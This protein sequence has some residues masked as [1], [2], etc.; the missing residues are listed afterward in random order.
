MNMPG[1]S[2]LPVALMGGGGG[3][4]SAN[5]NLLLWSEE[6][7]RST[8]VKGVGVAVLANQGQDE[9]GGTTADLVTLT[10]GGTLTQISTIA[11]S[12]GG[13]YIGSTLGSSSRARS[14]VS[15]EFDGVPYV[16]SV[17][18]E[19]PLDFQAEVGLVLFQSGG[20]IAARLRDTGDA[21][22]ILI[23]QAKLETPTLTAYVKREGT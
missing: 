1:I 4:P 16:F 20:F 21:P 15:G 9:Q 2:G 17:F 7:D 10:S 11:V 19:D 8:W 22:S 13:P 14:Q 3:A 12:V 6:L 23:S 5:P 18:V